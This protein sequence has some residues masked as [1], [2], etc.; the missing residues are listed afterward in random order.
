MTPV[1]R[2]WPRAYRPLRPV[3]L[4]TQLVVLVVAELGLYASYASHDARFHWATHF[5][6]ALLLTAVW[7][8]VHLLVAAR[9]ARGQLLTIL[10][11]HLWAM[12]PDLAFRAGVPHQRW[13]DW[14]ALGHVHVHYLPGGDTSWLVLSLAAVGGYVALLTSWLRARHSETARGMQ[15]GLGLGGRAVVRPQVDPRTHPLAHRHLM[16]GSSV[17]SGSGSGT[18]TAATLPTPDT[19]PMLLLHG[20]GGTSASW[21]AVGRQ[22]AEAG[23]PVLV[24]DL[25]GFGSSMHLGTRFRLSDQV[26]AVL[27]LLDHH[28]I[29]RVHL[30]GH[31]WGCVVAGSLATRAP[32]R[33]TRLTLVAPAAF[34]D[35]ALARERIGR[36][37]MLARMTFGSRDIGGLVCGLMCLSRPA[38][39]RVLPRLKR[40]LPADVVRGGVEHSFPAYR[41]ALT[42]MWRDNPLPGLLRSPTHPVAVVLAEG[43]QTVR[44]SDVLDLPP[45]GDVRVTRVQGTHGLPYE[46][47]QL[48]T[49]LVL[50]VAPASSSG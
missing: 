3:T 44:P 8:A 5:L 42:S 35:P 33:V 4:L 15:P 31:S 25:L 34:A 40:D 36:N 48:V 21:L 45:R 32:E 50:A 11:F 17:G 37:S 1:S 41:D 39:S 9:P 24:P 7:Q 29:T 12:W 14:V 6:V 43:D 19:T 28:D 27:R 22:L 2:Q 46:Q 38:L 23:H 20:L 26:D 47:P 16:P 49:G 13:M 30:V 18:A 10:V